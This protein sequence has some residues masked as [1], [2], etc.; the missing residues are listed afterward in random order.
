MRIP[1]C[2]VII[3]HKDAPQANEHFK[4]VN[5][6]DSIKFLKS[7]W[8][9]RTGW[10]YTDRNDLEKFQTVVGILEKYP[11][12]FYTYLCLEIIF[13]NQAD[14]I[15]ANILGSTTI[16]DFVKY[17]TIKMLTEQMGW[18]SQ[19][20]N[21]SKRARIINLIHDLKESKSFIVANASKYFLNSINKNDVKPN[22]Y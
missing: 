21:S 9:T 17:S 5:E 1:T 15:I 13:R 16:S 10:S 4:I 2:Q 14:F 11:K 18:L 19:E 22:G 8:S 6:S 12:E 7:N 3:S 20:N